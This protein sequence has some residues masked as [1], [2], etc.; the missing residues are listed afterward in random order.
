MDIEQVLGQKFRGSRCGECI[1]DRETHLAGLTERRYINPL[2]D[3]IGCTF[4]FSPALD[5]QELEQFQQLVSAQFMKVGIKD[6][7][8]QG[9]RTVQT[10][11]REMEVSF[12]FRLED[13][14]QG[15]RAKNAIDLQAIRARSPLRSNPGLL[16]PRPN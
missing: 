3:A 14:E 1:P 5:D 9:S 6:L 13:F 15:E 16:A 7:F 12:R 4:F 10:G 11:T 8:Y 2:A